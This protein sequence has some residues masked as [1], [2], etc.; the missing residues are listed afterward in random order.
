[1]IVGKSASRI[2]YGP[3]LFFKADSYG[4]IEIVT[5]KDIFSGDVEDQIYQISF[6][7]MQT[8]KYCLKRVHNTM[9]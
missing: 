6:S 1:M 9:A 2:C 3:V 7:I 4:K 5:L 8:M